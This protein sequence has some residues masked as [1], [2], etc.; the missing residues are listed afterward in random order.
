MRKSARSLVSSTKSKT[1]PSIMLCRSYAD[2]ISLNS[3]VIK[4]FRTTESAI[5]GAAGA[6]KISNIHHQEVSE[7]KKKNSLYLQLMP[8]VV[9][10]GFVDLQLFIYLSYFSSFCTRKIE[11]FYF[12]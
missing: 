2:I 8:S 11:L 6:K 3:C 10:M 12:D 1:A 4:A 7:N 5:R 9:S